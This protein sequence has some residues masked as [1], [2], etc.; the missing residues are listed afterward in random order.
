MQELIY[1]APQG[2]WQI[3]VRHENAHVQELHITCLIDAN[4]TYIWASGNNLD[5]LA[6]LIATAKAA[7]ISKSINWGND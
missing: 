1:V 6:S 5:S 7:I 4:P 3:E 2:D